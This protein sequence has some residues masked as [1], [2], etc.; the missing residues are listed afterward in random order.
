MPSLGSSGAQAFGAGPAVEAA[1]AGQ[2]G[3]LGGGGERAL[4]VP[5]SPPPAAGEEALQVSSIGLQGIEAKGDQPL[6]GV[7]VGV[8]S[9]PASRKREVAGEISEGQLVGENKLTRL[10]LPAGI[11]DLGGEW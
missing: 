4:P 5:P 1:E 6:D 3:G 9:P 8:G 2:L 10:P 11:D 7:Q